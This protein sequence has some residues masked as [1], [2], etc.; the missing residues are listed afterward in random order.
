MKGT[1]TVGEELVIEGTFDGTISG[2]GS[3]SITVLRLA[4]ISGELSAS[5]VRIEDG[6]NLE[7]TVLTGRI[8]VADKRI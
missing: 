1:L 6:T 3:D 8:T 5:E 4:R 2:N 7:N